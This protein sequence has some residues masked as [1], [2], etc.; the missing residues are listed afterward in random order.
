[1]FF[2]CNWIHQFRKRRQPN[3]CGWFDRIVTLAT[4]NPAI[5]VELSGPMTWVERVAAVLSWRHQGGFPG[6]PRYYYTN[7]R[8]SRTWL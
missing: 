8:D 1:M 3:N 4:A 5:E 2:N 6:I 7:A